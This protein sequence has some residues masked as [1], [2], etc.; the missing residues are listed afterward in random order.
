MSAPVPALP[1]DSPLAEAL[2]RDRELVRL[3]RGLARERLFFG[4]VLDAIGPRHKELG[5]RSFGMYVKERFSLDY[6][7]CS[8]ARALARRLRELPLMTDALRSH[9]IRWNV[10][11]EAS[12]HATAGDEA[13]L[14]E[15]IEGLGVRELRAVLRERGGEV[16]ARRQEAE[17]AEKEVP[18]VTVEVP[19]RSREELLGLESLRLGVTLVNEGFGE[20][21]QWFECAL[22]EATSTMAERLGIAPP[23]EL[24]SD[25]DEA[26]EA[27]RRGKEIIAWQESVARPIV[28]PVEA[29]LDEVIDE[30]D[31][32]G[33]GLREL[34]RLAVRCAAELTGRELWAGRVLSLF[35]QER[36]WQRLG[37]ASE[38]HYFDERLGISRST[39]RAR[40]SLVR[41]S[42]WLDGLYAAIQDGRIGYMHGS[43]V[44]RVADPDNLEAWIDRASRRT[45]K[46]L[47]EE[48]WAAELNAKLEGRRFG[49]RPPTDEE[50]REAFALEGELLTGKLFAS[51][52]GGP[53]DDGVGLDGRPAEPRR[54]AIPPGPD[55]SSPPRL[56]LLIRPGAAE[57]SP[58]GRAAPIDHPAGLPV[59][60]SSNSEPDLATIAA[61][62]SKRKV[63]DYRV[64][65]R[66]DV[67]L[68]YRALAK[69]FSE[70]GQPISF[71]MFLV[72][73]FWKEWGPI[74]QSGGTKWRH[75]HERDRFRCASP[76]CTSWICTL[77]HILYRAF[78]G[79]DALE[80]LITLCELCHLHGEHG[81]RLKVRGA[82]SEPTFT[83]GGE[84]PIMVVVGRE[85]IAA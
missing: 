71:T 81:G 46:N 32:D 70:A 84:H 37:Y 26:R 58:T 24:V 25:I 75:V 48:V 38:Q 49:K 7:P 62:V 69:S 36:D 9:R 83:F 57:P 54:P 12:R 64:R 30:P 80:N 15:A 65:V 44:A 50:L 19:V 33:L 13:E 66:E 14:L 73:A 85:K 61:L 52:F 47:L 29:I 51:I 5:L 68:Q 6:G 16:E 63:G 35:L 11:V 8:Q 18:Y 31:L 60:M 82:A 72:L 56:P 4:Q 41:K 34:D 74:L 77:H 20:Q 42:E 40:V 23:I 76:V 67:A 3:F 27:R 17:E 78:G 22:A 59:R 10:A 45:Y 79:S 2:R 55:P 28:P 21:G 1:V 43:L 53:D 39:A